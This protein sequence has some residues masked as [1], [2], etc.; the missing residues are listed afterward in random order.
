M[1]GKE[2][3]ASDV[4]REALAD[5]AFYVNSGG[6]VT[7]SGGEVLFQPR[8]AL[9]ILKLI[10]AEN[11]HTIV[12]T[13]GLGKESDLLSLV[14]YTDCFYYD[15]KLSD[16]AAFG[17]YIGKGREIILSNLKKLREA[18]DGILLRVPLIP[19]I[20][21]TQENLRAAAQLAASLK[22][23]EIQLL[24]YN[25]SAGAKY[26]W[27]GRPYALDSVPPTEPTPPDITELMNYTNGNVIVTI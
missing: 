3:R 5:K 15:Y 13:S 14:P 6:G 23:R 27:I 10:K 7:I 22:I 1:S 20:T 26:E 17:A 21:D 24:P 19:G 9:E 2:M 8:F 25:S 4:A 11:V 18:T 12:E 16:P